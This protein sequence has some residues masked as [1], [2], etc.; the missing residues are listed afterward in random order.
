[1]PNEEFNKQF[2]RRTRE[3]AIVILTFLD[4]VHPTQITKIMTNQL[5]KSGTSVGANFSAF[6]RARSQNERLSAIC[7]VMEESDGCAYWL[8]IFQHKKYGDPSWLV[9]L[10]QECDEIE[11][12]VSSV[13]NQLYNQSK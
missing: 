4:T 9:R 11:R 13:K 8:E 5:A 3:F 12:V 10:L 1:M 6:T 7:I 2:R